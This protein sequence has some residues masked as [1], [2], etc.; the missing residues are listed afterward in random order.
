MAVTN[1]HLHS[2]TTTD[3]GTLP[4]STDN[5]SAKTPLQSATGA[6]TNRSMDLTVNGGSVFSLAATLTRQTASQTSW[7]GRWCS[8][9]LGV[10]VFPACDPTFTANSYLVRLA[11]TISNTT[12]TATWWGTLYVWRPSTGAIVGT[13]FDV[14]VSSGTVTTSETWQ[15]NV[16]Q[17]DT[18]H[19]AGVTTQADDILVLEV[20]A[21]STES[22]A[23][24]GITL[25]AFL[26]GTNTFVSFGSAESSPDSL[27]QV[28]IAIAWAPSSAAIT[29]A[30]IS[31]TSTMGGAV[32]A[33]RP[34]TPAAV[35]AT[36]VFSGTVGARRKI[37]PGAISA[38][39]TV[40]GGITRLK[41][42]V[43]GAISATSTLSGS[44]H[45]ARAIKPGAVSATSVV[46][47][48]IRALRAIAGAVAATSVVSGAVRSL[49]KV[50]PGQISAT[51]VV[52]GAVRALRK[53]SGL[54]NAT[55]TVSGAVLRLKPITPGQISATSTVSGAIGRRRPIVSAAISAT[56][57]VSG[58][59]VA[60]RRILPGA[61]SATS[62]V[63]GTVTKIGGVPKPIAGAISAISA[64]SGYTGIF[65]P[66][67]LAGLT[68]WFDASQLALSDGASVA[69]WPDLSGNGNDA[70][71]ATG[72]TQ[73]IF[74]T[75]RLDGLPIVSF[76]G[77]DDNILTAAFVQS[78]E[79][80][81]CI[82]AKAN[83]AAPSL[84]GY[85]NIATGAT[86]VLQFRQ[87][88]A[89]S[90]QAAAFDSVGVAYL[91]DTAALTQTWQ[92]NSILHAAAVI[93][94]FVEGA[95]DG[96][97][98]ITGSPPTPT[99][100]FQLGSAKP[101]S[102]F[103]NVDIAEVIVYN[104]VLTASERQT[105]ENYLRAK[106]FGIQ[107]PAAAVNATSTV[108]GTVSKV[109]AGKFIS[110]AIAATSAVTGGVRKLARIGGAVSAVS[111][112]S[113]ALRALRALTGAV[114]ATSTVAGSVRAARKIAGNVAATSIVSGAI[115]AARRILP[116][117]I[118]ATSTVSGGIVVKR[119]IPVAAVAATSIVSG[120]IKLAGKI[121][122]LI[123]ATSTV[124]G[125][126]VARRKVA[127]AI[128]AT[129]IVAGSLRALRKISGAIAA[130]STVTGK[131]VA[132]R[133]ISGAVLAT[134]TV[135]G[136]IGRKRPVSG[137]ISATSTVAGAIV[138]LR[139]V[140]P[141]AVQAI[142]VVSG[143]VVS[144]PHSTFGGAVHA[145]S[146]VTGT[147]QPGIVIYGK[148]TPRITSARYDIPELVSGTST[149]AELVS[150]TMEAAQL[151]S[152]G[153]DEIPI[154][155]R[156]R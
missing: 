48:G 85:F 20:F 134:S 68:V 142:S 52:S 147:I 109:A 101:T 54:I 110:G 114:S 36:S 88:D 84:D 16:A 81:V 77:I 60:L 9:P 151:T 46:S 98:A 65:N 23:T 10:N 91:D 112:V 127:G 49:R 130:T 116:G 41:Q 119:R 26:N 55:S 64:I 27:L 78:A 28:P 69:T 37:S 104:R 122:G 89:S 138:V 79:R 11:A 90:V 154:I 118:S 57:I 47:G 38:T 50:I 51:S 124:A 44:I 3:T 76:D 113:G 56:S 115:R 13:I 72:T 96:S 2:A 66:A 61:I 6:E 24:T 117:A 111:T 135:T 45:A 42:I 4:G 148:T 153:D 149:Q 29:P 105:V 70:T 5:S 139:V 17:K 74:H 73:P 155:E 132:R 53:I 14:A 100:S 35:S 103:G 18:T 80:T 34:I 133:A 129:S 7:M 67:K 125:T 62:T 108:S 30:A 126:V 43:P 40:S 92:R 156:A 107:V 83:D 8:N 71:Q 19:T 106:W 75:N 99:V 32:T 123:S 141:G 63:S 137:A 146:T 39:S 145:F 22:M 58:G 25:T 150:G 94:T 95:S 131:I 120:A 152:A 121:S 31:A 97:T 144:R 33:K 86:R 12:G 82:L 59:I 143:A 21:D 1:L 87:E 128:A 140:S 15:S 93:E 102:Q 136:K